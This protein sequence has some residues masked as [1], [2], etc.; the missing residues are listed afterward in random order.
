MQMKSKLQALMKSGLSLEAGL[1]EANPQV[2]R[3]RHHCRSGSEQ[4]TLNQIRGTPRDLCHS[5][6]LADTQPESSQ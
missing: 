6:E 3:E 2:P 4:I 5:A 1:S